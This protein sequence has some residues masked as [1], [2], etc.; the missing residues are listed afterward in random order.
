VARNR[1]SS[2]LWHVLKRP[3][4]RLAVLGANGRLAQARRRGANVCRPRVR[5][6]VMGSK[7]EL[8]NLF[9][10]HLEN[11]GMNSKLAII[12]VA[13]LGAAVV[14][15][16]R[17]ST[18]AQTEHKVT[19][20]EDAPGTV[21]HQSVGRFQ[22]AAFEET[23]RGTQPGYHVIDTA[24][25]Q[26]WTTYN[27]QVKPTTVSEPLLRS[28][29]TQAA[30]SDK[31][32]SRLRVLVENAS[33][34]HMMARHLL[35]VFRGDEAKRVDSMLGFRAWSED[36]PSNNTGVRSSVLL[37]SGQ[38]T[39]GTTATTYEQDVL[40]A[41]NTASQSEMSD[42]DQLV[43]GNPNAD[44]IDYYYAVRAK[45]SCIPCHV[46]NGQEFLKVGELMG[47]VK[48]TIHD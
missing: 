42:V 12:I 29:E 44:S 43:S 11:F 35:R 26:V 30:V 21:D 37:P 48:L 19:V 8:V 18:I 6:E 34:S 20:R 14:F 27:G 47:V 7:P 32:Q 17:V 25:G 1:I 33:T 46:A 4:R 23:E 24:T 40:S 13:L 41:F 38:I 31:L 16:G 45:K 15:I 36:N 9:L 10:N 2:R 5:C 39:D 28:R 3:V 22:I